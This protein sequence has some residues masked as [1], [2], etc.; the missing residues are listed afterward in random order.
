MVTYSLDS[1]LNS[2]LTA[3]NANQQVLNVVANN[4]SNVNNPNY[5]RRI[6]ELSSLSSNDT[7][8]G[9]E[10]SS[11]YRSVNESLIA[12][13][14]KQQ[15]NVANADT[16]SLFYSRIQNLFGDP[17]S[18]NSLANNITGLFT[19]LDSLSLD[20]Q[21]SSLKLNV[22]NQA[23]VIAENINYLA[24]NLHQLRY[25]AD[26]QIGSTVNN[27]N[28]LLGQ[29]SSNNDSIAIGFNLGNDTSNLLETRDMLLN[30][31]AK[32]LDI[33]VYIAQ[34]GTVQISAAAGQ[35]LLNES[36]YIMQY[37]Q[38]SSL[39]GIINN[40]RFGPVT[41]SRLN[42]DGSISDLSVVYISGG[43]SES[44]GTPSNVTTNILSGK[45][46]ALQQL[47][48]V[49]IP[50]IIDE[51]DVLATSL[52]EQF[53]AIHNSGGGIPPATSLTGTRPVT[54]TDGRDFT[55]TSRIAILDNN[56]NPILR[57]DKT[58]L[59]PLLLNFDKIA[60]GG[61]AGEMTT[62]TIVN[63]INQY[64]HNDFIQNK[65]SIGNLYDVKLA[66]ASNLSTEPGGIMS[67]DLDIQND[68]QVSSSVQIT[69]VTVSGGCTGL[70][71]S[72]PAAAGSAAGSR[73]RTG[74][75]FT[76][77][78]AGGSGGPYTISV[79]VQN[80][81]TNGNI[82][83]GTIQYQ[84]N[85]NPGSTAVQNT[86]YQP[87]TA[88]GDATF[89]VAAA[90]N[91]I[92]TAQIVDAKG[93]PV[94][95]GNSGFLQIS[96]VNGKYGII[97]DDI[98]SKD[99]GLRAGSPYSV[100]AVTGTNK[101]FATYYELNDF[102]VRN[103][104][105]ISGTTNAAVT[106]SA[107]NLQLRSDILANP[108][109]ISTGKIVRSPS[110]PQTVSQGLTAAKATMQFNANP[111]IGDTITIDSQVFSFVASAVSNS[112]ITVGANLGITLD[113]IATALNASNAYTSGT[114]SKA[115]YTSDAI[116]LLTITYGNLGIIGNNYAISGNFAAAQVSV[117]NESYS[118][119][120]NGYLAGGTNHQVT[121]NVQPWTYGIAIGSNESIN[122]FASLR[123]Q[124][125]NFNQAGYL[126]QMTN[127]VLG[128]FSL[129]LS[130]NT[131]QTQNASDYLTEQNSV[132]NTLGTMMDAVGGVNLDQEIA[133]SM[134]Y[135][136]AYKASSKMMSLIMGLYDTLLSSIK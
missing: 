129:I 41:V 119:T 38:S 51:L 109:L 10:V 85:D 81:D 91:G 115:A 86:R 57:P 26:Q 54:N 92:A 35:E 39:Q 73:S 88:S 24:K 105:T 118:I 12:D 93:K 96:T 100:N 71:S 1:A 104:N 122:S 72:L 46:A 63:E 31:L 36:K 14:R 74:A 89:T 4:I 108:I 30:S 111:S 27:I 112:E 136:N 124:A 7:V 83:S 40:T 56:G 19:S 44:G 127:T 15:S 21:L 130:Y 117:N 132:Y 131:V 22:V 125:V 69:A 103:S 33:N 20:P 106:G 70:T 34:N 48:D 76:V 95:P 8:I 47:R 65:A 11:V 107:V 59:P 43:V 37:A 49:K 13:A 87:I 9:V 79:T 77:S 25:D 50:Q 6:A 28:S 82:S 121:V 110:A 113:N 97:M 58:P 60:S 78:F 90:I 84:V 64:F 99:K 3:L 23:N 67:F 16:L 133:S 123:S 80:T 17:N 2:S 5:S 126:P 120:P 128:Y 53:N 114:V 61:L 98:D 68:S 102:F 66:A 52:T 94:S 55:G 116:D 62:Q 134:Q 18:T 42:N 29:L 32:E 101:G 135:M 75:P 45:L